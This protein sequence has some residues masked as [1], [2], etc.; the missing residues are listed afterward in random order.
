MMH[1]RKRLTKAA[2]LEATETFNVVAEGESNFD[3]IRLPVALQSLGL[4]T[5]IDHSKM[6]EGSTSI[7][8][9]SFL[10]IVSACIDDPGWS[11]TEIKESFA[12]FDREESGIGEKKDINRVFMKLGEVLTDKNIDDQMIGSSDL[13][14]EGRISV[15]EFIQLCKNSDGNDLETPDE[16]H[17]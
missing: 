1:I 17:G 11:L 7:D 9:N 14:H 3:I 16:S 2:N 6:S 13:G 10:Q 15:E 8:L 12:T 4:S 5:K